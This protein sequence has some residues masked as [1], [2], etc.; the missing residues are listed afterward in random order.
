MK[1]TLSILVIVLTVAMAGRAQKA[2]LRLKLEAGTTYPQHMEMEAKIVQNIN[3][4][5]MEILMEMKGTTDYLVKEVLEGK[6]LMYVSYRSLAISMGLPQGK[7]EF[8]SEDP[9]EGDAFSK[10]LAAV[11]G[12]SFS[13]TMTETGKVEEIK[14]LDALWEESISGFEGISEMEKQQIKSQVANAYG[15]KGMKSSIETATAIFPENLVKKGDQWVIN[16]TMEAGMSAKATT[17]YTYL[18]KEGDMAMIKGKGVLETLNKEEYVETQGMPM[19]IEISGTLESDITINRHTGWIARAIVATDAE[20]TTH[21]KD[22]PQVP[23]G[24][25]IPMKMN[26]RQVIT[27]Q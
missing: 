22:N 26:N 18:G 8:S 25:S 1:R 10:I 17:T 3:G 9:A 16:T 23:G 14:G 19:R 4:M 20:G 24:M 12:K 7:V 27:G 6:Y 13:L 5:E 21:I 15:E 11:I 2:D